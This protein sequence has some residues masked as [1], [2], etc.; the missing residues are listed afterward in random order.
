LCAGVRTD[1]AATGTADAATGEL[2]A[3]GTPT[4]PFTGL[5]W[6]GS[7]VSM[8]AAVAAARARK[9]ITPVIIP[10]RKL[11]SSSRALMAARTPGH[12]PAVR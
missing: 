7:T 4:A 5:P 10:V 11:T 8:T 2:A 3:A 6:L 12:D 9:A 1:D